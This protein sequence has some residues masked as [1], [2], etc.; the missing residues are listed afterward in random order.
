MIFID[1]LRKQ[2]QVKDLE[3]L[4]ARLKSLI[5]A[6]EA[7]EAT[8]AELRTQAR[9]RRQFKSKADVEYLRDLVQIDPEGQVREA[10][11]GLY[12]LVRQTEYEMSTTS[13][14]RSQKQVNRPTRANERY[15]AKTQPRTSADK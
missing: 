9:E 4:R 1:K 6:I 15:Q 7:K 3:K 10:D 12:E 2:E 5:E 13:I 11:V 8:N 14:N